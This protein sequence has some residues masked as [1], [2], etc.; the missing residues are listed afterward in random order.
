MKSPFS[1]LLA[2][3]L[4]AVLVFD[5]A[6][7]A[8][9]SGRLVGPRF[10]GASETLPFSAVLCI[11]S[12][13]GPGAETRA[14]RTWETDPAGWFQL[15]G[16][17]GDYT[18][19][20]TGPAH[21]IRPIV[22]NNLATRP[23]DIVDHLNSVPQFDFFTFHEG[24]WDPQ[25]ATDYFQTFVARGR[26]VTQIGFRL[27]HDGMDG[28][29]P[30][31]Q[32]LRVSIHRRT[33]AAPERWPQIGPSVPVLNV[34]S[35]GG[36]N[37]IWSAGWNSGEVP[38]QPGETYAVHLCAEIPG[39]TFQAFWRSDDET[40]ADCY[41]LGQ[42]TNGWQKHDL[43]LAV[44][45][46]ND[47]LLIPYNKKVHQQFG[48]FAGF[49]RLWSQ[50]Y[51]AQGRSLAA[52]VLYAAT[53]GAQPPLSRQRAAVRVRRGGPAGPVV[54]IEKIAIGNGNYTGDASWGMLCVAFAPGEV[55]L[56]PGENYAVEFE[57]LE[58]Y[59]TLHGF[60]N[61]KG[62]VS[63]DR[64]GFNPYRKVAPD[65]YEAGTAYKLGSEAMDFDLDLQL[66][67]YEHA[68]YRQHP[69][70]DPTNLLVNGTMDNGELADQKGA[71]QAWTPFAVD[72]G[73]T[74]A[75]LAEAPRHTNRFARVIGGGFNGQSVDGGFVQRVTEL[76]PLHTYQLT[77]TVR[78]SWALDREHQCFVGFDRTGQETDPRAATINWTALPKLH[79]VFVSYTSEPIRPATN[80]ISVWLR[81]RT[82]LKTDYPFKADFDDFA[83]RRVRTEPPDAD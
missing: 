2:P 13:K 32:N 62:Q 35:G 36:K 56:T 45:T 6:A 12:P 65:R 40:S 54:G 11:A 73:T 34:D 27:A 70:V 68:D 5:G 41:R 8:V 15:N 16:M 57:S 31:R 71:P 80:A 17:G 74:H 61:L 4:S 59:E 33:D 24:E 10:P 43:W 22:R 23:G 75:Y 21:L 25:R 47:G 81:G 64:P 3:A 19:V 29:G 46:D 9:L 48:E 76:S 39:R 51:R 1:L 83:L 20:F 18:L 63:D 38:L 78:S 77:G 52:A 30:Q 37:Y 44:G 7:Q 26:S 53:G 66:L 50:T 82:T 79:G 28:F 14:F 69:P 58:N 55:P 60:V 42:G 72:P 49:A 67:E